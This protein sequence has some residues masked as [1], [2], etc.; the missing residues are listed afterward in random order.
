MVWKEFLMN[1]ECLKITTYFGERKQV[2][3]QFVAESLLDLYE[4]HEIATSILLRGVE[5][6]GLKHHLRTDTSLS[7]SEDLPAVA[8]AVDTRKHIEEVLDEAI[9]ASGSGL[10]TLERARMQTGK[11]H[12]FDFPEELGEATKLTIYLGRQERVYR[13]PAF[14]AVCDLLRRRGV[15][16][17]S[18]LLGVDGTALGKRVRAQFF[19]RNVDVPIMVIAVGTG[20]QISQVLPELS[21]LIHRPL[22]TLER[23]QICKSN[24]KLI[25]P[26][27]MLPETD[28]HGMS[29]WQ[30]LMIHTTES[31]LHGGQ[32]INRALI[33]RLRSAG[34]SGATTLRCIWGYLGDHD[35][36]GDRIMQF[37]RNVPTVTI[38]IDSP[39]RIAESFPII[40]ELTSE[41]GLVTS[42]IVPAMHTRIGDDSREGLKL[43]HHW[44]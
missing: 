38:V 31:E 22:V 19:S 40:D 43:A 33:R 17:A 15:T 41:Y 28:V 32:P 29:L 23:V 7:L 1:E 3:R 8:I 2:G 44:F 6:F 39:K 10:V 26:P 4:R 36:H 9:L 27:K 12:F 34:I 30:K 35:P 18:V 42:E 20:E 13:V 5:G 21:G 11:L 16:G 37:G 25:E 14:V 24:G